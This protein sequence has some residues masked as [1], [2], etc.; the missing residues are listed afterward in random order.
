MPNFTSGYPKFTGDDKK[1]IK[2]LKDWAFN[3][4]D[5]LNFVLSNLDECNISEAFINSLKNQ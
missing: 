4:T 2:A 3:L 1:D 5:E